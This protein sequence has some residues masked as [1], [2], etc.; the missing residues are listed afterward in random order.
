M[1]LTIC[2]ATGH[3][4][5]QVTVTR[6]SGSTASNFF[7]SVPAVPG[8]A[9]FCAGYVTTVVLLGFL[10]HPLHHLDPAWFAI[11]GATILCIITS[12]MDVEDIMHVSTANAVFG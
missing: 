7:L 10:L 8:L 9:F 2:H 12:R 11:I 6:A 4:K 3:Q 5:Q 1:W